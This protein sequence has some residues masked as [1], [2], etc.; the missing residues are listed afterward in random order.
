MNDAMVRAMLDSGVKAVIYAA[1]GNGN[2]A[3][4]I[5]ASLVDARLRG[6]HVVRGSR[7]GGGVVIRNAAQPDDRYDWLV[8]DDQVPHKAR[9]LMMLALTGENCARELQNAFLNY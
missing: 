1:T 2:V 5:V 8:T 4:S 7:T 3:T 6:I 9:I